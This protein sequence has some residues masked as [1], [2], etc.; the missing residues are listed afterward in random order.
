MKFI[1]LVLLVAGCADIDCTW[2]RDK[3]QSV[4]QCT[5][6]TGGY[7]GRAGRCRATLDSGVRLTLRAPVTVGDELTVC[8]KA[9][10]KNYVWHIEQPHKSIA[11]TI[12][13]Y[14]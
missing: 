6:S 2:S 9:N 4:H 12:G 3:V 7:G 1:L 11:S 13:I 8:T 14:R 5:N 10:G